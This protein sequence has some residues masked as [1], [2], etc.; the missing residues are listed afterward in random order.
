MKKEC[1]ENQE[2]S[3]ETKIKKRG[4]RPVWRMKTPQKW[5]GCQARYQAHT[6]TWIAAYNEFIK[7]PG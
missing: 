6:Y 2:D 7:F 5:I 4:Q 1:N 3:I